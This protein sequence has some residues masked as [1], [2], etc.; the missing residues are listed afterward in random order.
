M[1]FISF[2][3]NKHL[4][5]AIIYW[6]IEIITRSF[7]YFKWDDYFEIGKNNAINEYIYVILLN[8]SD[9]IAGFL[10][11]YINCSL[12]KKKGSEDKDINTFYQQINIISG[13]EEEAK[14]T[15]SFIFKIM[16]VC[17]LDYL[18]RSVFYI[19]Y[20]IIPDANHDDISHKTQKDVINNLDIISRYIFSIYI[21]KTKVFKHHK[22]SIFII[23]VGFLVLIVDDIISA[24]YFYSDEINIKLNCIYIGVL[25]FRGIF[26][27]FEDTIVKKLFT[28]DYIIPEFIMFIRGLGEFIIILIITPFLYF[29]FLDDNNIFN[30]DNEL[31]SIILIIIAYIL[32][33]FIKAYLILKVIY[34]FSSQSVS[35]LIISESITG[36]ITE[37]INYFISNKSNINLI[38]TLVIDV[39][40]ILITTFGTLIYDEIIVIHKLGM[41]NNVASEISSRAKSE[42]DSISIL[43]DEKDKEEDIEDLNNSMSSENIYE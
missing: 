2:K 29:F 22:V 20:Q 13:R 41:D 19:F 34:Y 7:T 25:S 42:I 16:L 15:K 1:S 24:Y 31:L 35:F 39:I 21:L 4:I 43:D 23:S 14:K 17:S 36:A 26:F 32:S 18:N 30:P 5:F 9:L 11:L 37:I 40:M 12:K 8:I 27:P 28:E 10:V 38:F 3:Y 33:S 6:L